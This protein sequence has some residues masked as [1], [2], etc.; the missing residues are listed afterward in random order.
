MGNTTTD[1]TQTEALDT[2]TESNVVKPTY[3]ADDIKKSV[4]SLLG[5][6][7]SHGGHAV[8]DPTSGTVYNN[9][10]AARTAGVTNWVY[11]YKWLDSHP[12]MATV[13]TSMGM[14]VSDYTTVSG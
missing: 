4:L 3:S 12:D 7:E 6:G 9:P 2:S 13:F 1:T 11:W 10:A 14:P 5:T 8:V